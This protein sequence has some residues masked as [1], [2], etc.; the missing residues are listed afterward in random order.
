MYY[1]GL[2]TRPIPY[3]YDNLVIS[4]SCLVCFNMGFTSGFTHDFDSID[5]LMIELFFVST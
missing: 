2:Q 5:L 1:G 3:K 4:L